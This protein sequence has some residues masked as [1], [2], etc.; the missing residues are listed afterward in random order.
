MMENNKIGKEELRLRTEEYLTRSCGVSPAEATD[1]EIYRAVSA[2]VR[3]TLAGKRGLFRRKIREKTARRV[4]YLCMEFLV[5]R[6][7]KNALSCLGIR[8]AAEEVIRDMDRDP[9]MIYGVER[10]PGLGNGGLGRLAAC[11]M[12]SLTSL[13]YPATGYSICYEDGFFR[14]KLLEG[15]QIEKTDEWL[16]TGDVWLVPR[17][18]R[19][20][21][22]RMGGTVRESWDSGRCTVSLEDADEITAVPWDLMVPGYGNG[23]VNVIRLWR[24]KSDPSP[25]VFATQGEYARSLREKVTPAALSGSLY[26]SDE[27]DDGKLLRLSQQYFLVSASVRDIINDHIADGGTVGDLPDRVAIHINDTHPALVIPEMMRVLMDVYSYG[28]EDAWRT[29]IST[30]TYTNHTVMPEAL[31]T[32]N[33]ELFRIRLPRIHM[34]IEEINRRLCGDLW[35]RHPGDWD[36]I[37][38]MAV[39]AFSSVRMANLSVAAARVVNGV[40]RLHTDILKKK[41]FRDFSKDDPSKFVNVTNGVSHRRWLVDANPGLASLVKEAIGDG[42]VADPSHLSD[43]MKFADD[44]SFLEKLAGIK[45]KNKERL[46]ALALSSGDS[47]VDPDSVF[48]VHIKRM[49]EYKRQLLGVLKILYLY[50]KIIDDPNC[51]FP[52]VTFIFGGKA[53]PG[54]RMAKTVIRLIWSVG[55]KIA[56]D[57]RA[58]DRL[59]VLFA[60]DYNVTSAEAIIPAADISEQISLAGKEAS[61]T[62]CMKMM[63]NG[64]VTIGTLDGANVEIKEA[65]G[66]RNIYI[67]G[68]ND[69]EVEEVWNGGYE[70]VKYYLRSEKIRTA[71]SFLEGEIAG[72]RFD[73]VLNYLLYSH[74]V[75]DPYMC[76]ADFDSYTAEWERMICDTQNKGEWRLKSLVNIAKS[77]YFSSDRSITEYAEKIWKISPLT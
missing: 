45:R 3:D 29:V 1:A 4:C 9:E 49:H 48:D 59:K 12:D 54:Y 14:Q 18:E 13:G 72:R 71:V 30:V 22:V 5:G 60:E 8:G 2:A 40:S 15:E 24:A 57:K 43:L 33:S 70:S 20:I 42:F 73:G 35:I 47:P 16:S 76:L 51:D 25:S 31:E 6:N 50:G 58:R 63:M 27:T 62:G 52:P 77:G 11:Y 17:P 64:A 37:S 38:R 53:A 67:F 7:L 39:T 19:A 26:P 44:A 36:R 74:G 21:A 66:E 28:W 69:A 55:E 56:R 34:I 61:G 65:V 10:D 32:W 75:P 41:V 46:A 23:A 68:M